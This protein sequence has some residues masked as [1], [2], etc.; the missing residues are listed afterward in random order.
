MVVA[1]TNTRIASDRSDV[2]ATWVG[3]GRWVVMNHLRGRTLT[4]V[5]AL[6]VIQFADAVGD[7]RDV[8]PLDHPIWTD[9]GSWLRPVGLS[10][11]E[12]VSLLDLPCDPRELPPALITQERVSD[13]TGASRS[14][15]QAVLGALI[16]RWR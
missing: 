10:I 13:L 3:E 6:G 12:A 11:R 1:I 4:M 8:Y 16:G 7:G 5:Q 14:L 15:V 9:A 2:Y